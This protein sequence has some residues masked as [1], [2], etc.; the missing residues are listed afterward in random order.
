[1]TVGTR[2]RLLLLTSKELEG[3]LQLSFTAWEL[4][5]MGAGSYSHSPVDSTTTNVTVRYIAEQAD[6]Q[7]VVTVACVSA[8][9]ARLSLP[10]L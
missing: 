8:G 1:M 4:H 9:C 3:K 10:A 5:S 7:C 2:S 6:I